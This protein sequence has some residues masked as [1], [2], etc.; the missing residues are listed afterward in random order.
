MSSKDLSSLKG[1]G[2]NSRLAALVPEEDE[3]PD[4]APLADFSDA[5]ATNAEEQGGRCPRMNHVGFTELGEL[6]VA[7]PS[8]AQLRGGTG[9]PRPR[10]HV[11]EGG[12]H[13]A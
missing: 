8:P 1:H 9:W 10:P 6:E 2:L 5:P 7:E 11:P 4:A 3:L 12:G 13:A